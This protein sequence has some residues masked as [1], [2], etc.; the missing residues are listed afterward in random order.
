MSL[1]EYVKMQ[2]GQGVV[3]DGVQRADQLT[4]AR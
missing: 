2:K 4:G 3:P 1:D